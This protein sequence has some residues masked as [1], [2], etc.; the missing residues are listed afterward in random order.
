MSQQVS[1]I[2]FSHDQLKL[3]RDTVAKGTTPEQF[4]LFVEVCRLSGLNPFAR[5]IYA[6]VRGGQMSIQTSIDG[7]RL[8]AERSGKYAGQI[9][10]Q[11]CAEDGVW[12]DVWLADKAPAAARVGVLRKDFSQPVWGVAKY[13]SYAQQSPIW[14]KMPDL[15]LSKCFS[16]DTEVLTDKGFQKFSEV[17]GRVLQVTNHG[18]DVSD[19]KPFVQDYSGDMVTLESDDLNFCVT[20]NHDMVTTAGKVEARDM[21]EQ[22]RA[23]PYYWIPRTVETGHWGSDISGESTALAAAF[24]ADGTR[25]SNSSFRIEVSRDYKIATLHAIGLYRDETQ[26]E[27]KGVSVQTATRTI[28]SQTDKSKFTYDFSLI[29]WLCNPDK[30]IKVE[31]IL[32]LSQFQAQLLVD[33]WIQFDGHTSKTTGVRRFYTSRL[34]HLKAFELACVV[35]GYTVS[36]R[37]SRTSDI[38]TRPNYHV[39]I[40]TR[41]EIPVFR[42]GRDY[43]NVGGNRKRM[44][45]GLTITQNTSGKVWCVTVPSGVIVVR[46]NGFSM[47]CGNCAESLALRKAFPAEMSGIYTHEEMQQADNVAPLPTVAP[48]PSAEVVESEPPAE[49]PKPAPAANDHEPATEQQKNAIRQ[50]SNKL[51]QGVPEDLDVMTFGSAKAVIAVLSE[52]VKSLRKAS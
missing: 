11:W 47:L 6:V 17:T 29:E 50:L 40:S 45:T 51:Q 3:V 10:P 20:P 39:T 1:V 32:Q 9:G 49:A 38:S 28:T 27:Y 5:Q 12:L 8:L 44:H 26:R 48:V 31:N 24:L 37:R 43:H 42:W 34:D 2:Q 14:T 13:K 19:A 30:S 23:R 15:M 33:T 35:A 52:D 4:N 18:L 36:P 46:R 16:E 41:N 21:Y 25:V 7:Y 22:S